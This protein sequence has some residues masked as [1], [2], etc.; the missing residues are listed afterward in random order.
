MRKQN[1]YITKCICAAIIGLGWLMILAGA[2][3]PRFGMTCLEYTTIQFLGSV[4]AVFA[5][6]PLAM[7]FFD[8]DI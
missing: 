3:G 7:A 5:G 2:F 4:Q 8:R 1:K 6:M